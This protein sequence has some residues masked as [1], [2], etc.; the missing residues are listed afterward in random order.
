MTEQEQIEYAGLA[1]TVGRLMA[2]LKQTEVALAQMAAARDDAL[3]RL[4]AEQAAPGE[5]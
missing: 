4:L 3:A 2:T 5:G 1:T